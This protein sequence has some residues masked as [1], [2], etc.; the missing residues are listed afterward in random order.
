LIS[1]T[2]ENFRS[3]IGRGRG[4]ES[5]LSLSEAREHANETI[6]RFGVSQLTSPINTIPTETGH[7][8]TEDNDD[9]SNE[10]VV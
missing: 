1:E 2:S 7:L 5:E 4:K 8:I 10:L 9:K 3:L 6:P